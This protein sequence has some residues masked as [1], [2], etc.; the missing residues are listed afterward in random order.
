M[1]FGRI[2]ALLPFRQVGGGKDLQHSLFRRLTPPP[3][4]APQLRVLH[5][6]ADLI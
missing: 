3:E 4:R 1:W 6:V 5:D 2:E